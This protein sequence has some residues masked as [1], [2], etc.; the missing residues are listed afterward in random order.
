MEKMR[1]IKRQQKVRKKIEGT[2]EVIV[3]KWKVF[4]N[5]S[6]QVRVSLNSASFHRSSFTRRQLVFL[7]N[8]IAFEVPLLS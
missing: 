3:F 1:R 5:E 2:E 8:Q 6:G 7:N 4:M